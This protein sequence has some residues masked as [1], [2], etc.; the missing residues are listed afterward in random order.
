MRPLLSSGYCALYCRSSAL[1]QLERMQTQC[2]R[3]ITGTNR[4]TPA[5]TLRLE[6]GIIPISAFIQDQVDKAIV[7][8]GQSALLDELETLRRLYPRT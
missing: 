7:R 4:W 2:I 5:S 6:T 3:R 1:E 8:F